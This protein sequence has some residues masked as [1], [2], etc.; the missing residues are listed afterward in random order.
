MRVKKIVCI[1]FFFALVGFPSLGFTQDKGSEN[2]ELAELKQQILELQRQMDEMKSKHENEIK[3]LKE[4]VEKLSPAEP[5]TDEVKAEEEA[6]YL[7]KLA[8]SMAGE[9]EEEKTPEETVF[10]FGGLS[11]QKLNPEISV[12]GDFVGHYRNQSGTRERSDAEIRGLELNFQSYLDPFS[13]LKA[14]THISDDGVDLEEV[15]LTRF[16]MFKNTNLDLGRFRQQFGIVNRWH[17]DALD[18]VKYPLALRN[19]FG[20]GGLHQTGASVEWILPKWGKAHQGLTFQVTNTENERLFGGDTMGNPSLLFH[21][22]NYRDLSRDTYLEFGLSG[23]FGWSDE[24]EVDRGGP[25]LESEYDSLGT[26]VYG[27]DLSVLWE[28]ADK[29]LYRNVEWR[30]EVYFLNRDILAP[31]DSGRDNL[32]AWGAYSYLQT[33]I[34]RNLDI[35]VRCDYFQPDTK[36]Y[37]NVTGA[38]MRPLAYTADDAYRWQICPYITWWQSEFVKFRAEYDYA[39]GRGMENPEHILWFQAI[40]AAGPHKHERY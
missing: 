15:Y 14:T 38:S 25:A 35:G 37:A 40:F 36:G 23:L 13:R 9:K 39:D 11:L 12:S 2:I 6:D 30:S 28:P 26:Q 21:Y 5:V 16:S 10:K 20:D 7:R 31:D 1:I 8:E 33:K 4:K 32:Q 22:K 3:A 24:W 34:A 29:A 18:Q 19:I 27:A 17:E